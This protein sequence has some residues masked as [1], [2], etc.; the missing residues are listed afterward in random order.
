MTCKVC[1]TENRADALYCENCGATLTQDVFD[2][3][4][5][6][7]ESAPATPDVDPGKTLGIVSMILGIAS[8]T[9]GL[10]CSCLVPCLGYV[11]PLALAIV[12]IVLG[13]KAMER[14]VGGGYSPNTMG[15]VGKTL[16]IISIVLCALFIAISLILN[17]GDIFTGF[18]DP[19]SYGYYGY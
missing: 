16:G 6:Q 2:E 1:N 5:Y 10:S 14:S 15:K 7:S 13:N 4:Q 17:L 3:N 11:I 8:P 19:Y 9:L 18:S 12:A